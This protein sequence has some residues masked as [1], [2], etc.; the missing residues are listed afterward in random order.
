MLSTMT[1]LTLVLLFFIYKGD[2]DLEQS[3]DLVRSSYQI[4][5]TAKELN[6]LIESMIAE[7]RGYLLSGEDTFLNSYTDQKNKIS[8]NLSRLSELN[9]DFPGQQS[10][11]DEIR[12]FYIA[13]AQKLE[14]RSKQLDTKLLSQRLDDVE[15]IYNIKNDIDR[16]NASLINMEYKH[17][18]EHI[19]ALESLKNYYLLILFVGIIVSLMLISLLNFF[20]FNAERK[21]QL[22]ATQLQGAE[23][24]FILAIEGTQ[25]GIFDWDIKT[26]KVYYSKRF[27]AM[28]GY[29]MEAGYYDV[30]TSTQYVH[31]DDQEGMWEHI[32]LYLDGKLSE[33][34]HDFR[35][36]SEAGRWVWIKSRGKA[37]FDKNGKAYRMVGAHTD[38]T[39][40]IKYQE[41][42]ENE[43]QQAQIAN[44]AKTE[45]LAHMSHEIRTPLTAISGIAEILNRKKDEFNEKQQELIKT[46][47]NSSGNLKDLINDILDF[48]KIEN[49]ELELNI[50]KV[51]LAELFEGVISMMALKA[52]EKGISFV[53]DYGNIAKD[54]EHHLFYSDPVR[55]RQ[56]LINL[57]GNAIKFTDEGGVTIEAEFE[58]REHIPFLRVN[59]SDTG[60]GIAAEN[61]DLIFDR[62]KQADSTV[63]RRFGGTGLGL[64]ISLRL[65][66]LL[67]GNI[68]VSSQT[69]V[70]STFSLIIPLNSA[71]MPDNQTSDKAKKT[72]TS[73]QDL[74]LNETA[75]LN[76]RALIVEDYEGN[77]IL[78]STIL[79]DLGLE[80][81]I[82]RN[83]LEALEQLEKND[84]NVV[85]MDIQMPKMDG[86]T[87]VSKL[88]EME[89]NDPTRIKT[90]V[91]GMTAH[92][93][94]GD[95]NKCIEAGMDSYLPKP[96]VESDLIKELHRFLN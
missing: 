72:S 87:A 25:D 7:Q 81:D 15:D 86:F 30:D 94:V 63:S 6:A 73:L 11:I 24:R 75:F 37:L 16:V 18:N 46:L 77:I 29:D 21:K 84:Y 49:G 78:V 20:L 91:I 66:K 79:E 32:N 90:P 10:R 9:E 45:F 70:G 44:D 62:F 55:F 51:D 76:K 92:A 26:N 64:P 69:G 4:I 53:F 42:L 57:I 27:F 12:L 41:K 38:I 39:H 60:I 5:A 8:Q 88:R 14:D 54:L 40:I 33:Y 2:K 58:E 96:L 52:G 34:E 35:M 17:L 31:P 93:L 68:S 89:T 19:L 50:Q 67:G 28:L 43:K 65:A 71:N 82:A 74:A 3:D 47:N 95:K 1:A 56:I 80:H 83:G 22:F 23:E 85:L 13:L 59:V 61:F 48:S 36:K